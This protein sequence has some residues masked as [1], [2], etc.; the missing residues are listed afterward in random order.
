MRSGGNLIK[1]V[2]DY[3]VEDGGTTKIMEPEIVRTDFKKFLSKYKTEPIL[4][5]GNIPQY[6][7]I[8]EDEL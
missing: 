4:R 5:I 7:E 6:K 1:N 2:S 3:I 8:C